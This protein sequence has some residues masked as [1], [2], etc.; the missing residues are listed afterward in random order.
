MVAVWKSGISVVAKNSL[1]LLSHPGSA[2]ST[3]GRSAQRVQTGASVLSHRETRSA[4]SA[5]Q[6]WGKLA[7]SCT[8]AQARVWCK[9]SQ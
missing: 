9:A 4:L 7:T 8:V 1:K 5:G 3:P 6:L 2:N